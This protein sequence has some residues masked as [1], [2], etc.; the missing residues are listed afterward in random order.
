MRRRQQG[1]MK[2]INHEEGKG[3]KTQGHMT[4]TVNKHVQNNKIKQEITVQTKKIQTC[5][6]SVTEHAFLMAFSVLVLSHL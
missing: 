2:T 4:G 5:Y 1:Q 3:G 6:T